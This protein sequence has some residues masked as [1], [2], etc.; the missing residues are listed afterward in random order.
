MLRGVVKELKTSLEQMSSEEE[1]ANND[2]AS[3]LHT[4]V[5][6]IDVS[7]VLR[8]KGMLPVFYG[9]SVLREGM[10]AVFFGRSVF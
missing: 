5:E 2:F 6:V 9:R 1:S 3:A 8:G 10:S 7:V 4:F